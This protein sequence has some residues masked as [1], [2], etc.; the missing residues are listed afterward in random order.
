[1]VRMTE[2]N[3]A[4]KAVLKQAAFFPEEGLS[5]D[6]FLKVLIPQHQIA[7][8]KLLQ[9]GF[10]THTG[11]GGIALSPIIKGNCPDRTAWDENVRAFLIRLTTS[12]AEAVSDYR[13]AQLWAEQA[14]TDPERL[15]MLVFQHSRQTPGS[16]L[17]ARLAEEALLLFAGKGASVV[18]T[19]AK[20]SCL[21]EATIGI[22]QRRNLEILQREAMLV[23]PTLENVLAQ[24]DDIPEQYLLQ[25]Y[26]WI[27]RLYLILENRKKAGVYIDKWRLMMAAAG[28]SFETVERGLQDL[29]DP[30]AGDLTVGAM[31]RRRKERQNDE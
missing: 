31:L 29:Y 5:C 20:R 7:G 25:A 23:V 22:E 17:E 3:G 24:A 11:T 2:E 10:L 14:K 4:R 6:A 27:A 16:P 28:P 12:L 13:N 9:E 21:I 26:G 18:L 1:M 30:R 15:R 8:R 19:G